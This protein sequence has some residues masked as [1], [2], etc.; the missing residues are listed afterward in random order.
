MAEDSGKTGFEYIGPAGHA[1]AITESDAN[2][3]DPYPRA[4]W[5][6]GA[7]DLYVDMVGGEKDVPFLAVPAGTMMPIRITKLKAAST[8]SNVTMIW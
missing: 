5:I 4:L 6:G 7:G 2:Y 1:K 3:V 8:V